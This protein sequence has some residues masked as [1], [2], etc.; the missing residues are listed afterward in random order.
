VFIDEAGICNHCRTYER[1]QL[2]LEDETSLKSAL[3]RR[4]AA[5]RNNAKGE[6]DVVVLFGGGKDS[7]YV[8]WAMTQVHKLR[9]LAVTHNTY[10]LTDAARHNARTVCDSLG[11]EL[12][13]VSLPLD[14]IRTIYQAFQREYGEF[15]IACLRLVYSAGFLCASQVGAGG[16]VIGLS[17]PQLFGWADWIQRTKELITAG[18]GNSLEGKIKFYNE[19]LVMRH[20]FEKALSVAL[21]SSQ[22]IEQAIYDLC[23]LRFIP[24]LIPYYGFLPDLGKDEIMKTVHTQTGWEQPDGANDFLTHTDCGVAQ[25]SAKLTAKLGQNRRVQELAAMARIGWLTCAQAELLIE[26]AH[27]ET[28]DDERTLQEQQ[29]AVQLFGME[30]VPRN[31]M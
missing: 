16:V 18:M 15:C 9:V 4:L 8:L 14:V 31:G 3:D 17:R 10:F 25:Y 28:F 29:L 11:C 22:V 27:R 5:C 1:C 26:Q 13:E 6:F 20:K 30:I 12:T 24:D 7:T 23:Q 19:Q 21:E 2:L